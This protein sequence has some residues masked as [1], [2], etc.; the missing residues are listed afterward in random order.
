MFVGTYEHALDAKGR[1]VLPSKFRNRL[2]QAGYLAPNQGCVA[3]WPADEFDG[4]VSRVRDRVRAGG[5]DPNI[6]RGLSA[7]AEEV[8]PDAQGRI[9]V[10]T[11]LRGFAD[12]GSEVIVTGAFDHI[13]IWNVDRWATLRPDLDETIIRAFADGAGA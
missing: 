10:P 12:L 11:H 4:M 13:E 6:L 7:Y 5:E 2:A 8:T 1:V 3:L 9:V